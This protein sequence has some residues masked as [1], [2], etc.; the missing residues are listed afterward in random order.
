MLAAIP[1]LLLALLAPSASAWRCFPP[2]HTPVVLVGNDTA[3]MSKDGKACV[4]FADHDSCRAAADEPE[5][6]MRGLICGQT[7]IGIYG[8]SGYAPGSWC[9]HGKEQYALLGTNATSPF[10]RR[11][12]HKFKYGVAIQFGADSPAAYSARV[13]FVPSVWTT[14]ERISDWFTVGNPVGI[15][16]A[17]A[18]L[19]QGWGTLTINMVLMS[20]CGLWCIGDRGISQL[21]ES[22]RQINALG[23][24]VLVIPLPEPNGYWFSFGNQPD[25][26]GEVY[27]RIVWGVRNS[28]INGDMV[29]FGWQ[30]NDATTYPYGQTWYA[31]RLDTNHNGYLDRGDD[32]WSP[33][34][35]GD[36]V[37]DWIGISAY[38]YGVSWPWT[39]GYP[40]DGKVVGICTNEMGEAG[41]AGSGFDL[42]RFAADRGK[43]FAIFETA[44]TYFPYHNPGPGQLAIQSAWWRQL[45]SEATLNRLWNLR[46]IV[47][48]E[49]FKHEESSDRDFRA[50]TPPLIDTF[51]HD[52]PRHLIAMPGEMYI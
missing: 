11:Q 48:F 24:R 2:H 23:I 16:W 27:R 32:P 52:L 29:K 43:P 35:P 37:V 17:L 19:G 51:R 50:T 40:A 41:R 49:Y 4:W 42:H 9:Q 38:H 45:Y 20:D 12:G 31:G 46:M 5:F 13:G 25:G 22:L 10:E 1:L 47:W 7:M 15:A 26:Y 14:Y 28:G 39:N 8:H 30:M 36:E 21:A 44:A 6:G 33:Y 34:Y 3:C 18:G